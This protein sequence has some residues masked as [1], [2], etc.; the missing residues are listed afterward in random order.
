MELLYTSKGGT[1]GRLGS[2]GRLREAQGG[3]T[4]EHLRGQGPNGRLRE[5]KE[6]EKLLTQ[7]KV[8][9]W[10]IEGAEGVQGS[11]RVRGKV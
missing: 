5:G 4:Q 1:P 11:V 7:P 3:A 6:C 2:I 8:F 9:R 10:E